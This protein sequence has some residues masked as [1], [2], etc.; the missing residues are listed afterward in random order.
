MILAASSFALCKLS[1]T[2]LSLDRGMASNRESSEWPNG[3]NPGLPKGHS[4]LNRSGL[5]LGESRD[6][7]EVGGEGWWLSRN[8]NPNRP[9]LA[10]IKP[11]ESDPTMVLYRDLLE[12]W[13]QP[14]SH[15]RGRHR[16][17]P[18]ESIYVINATL[19]RIKERRGVVTRQEHRGVVA[20][21]IGTTTIAPLDRTF[22]NFT[23]SNRLIVGKDLKDICTVKLK[24]SVVENFLKMSEEKT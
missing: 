3:I 24:T 2:A 4:K 7:G 21:R 5:L 14:N 13:V 23:I 20:T 6:V 8:K 1:A 18:Q 9:G 11:A 17:N 10:C 19:R 15:H 12:A 22:K 16:L